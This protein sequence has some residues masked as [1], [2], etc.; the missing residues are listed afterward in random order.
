VGGATSAQRMRGRLRWNVTV[1]TLRC[2]LRSR[3]SSVNRIAAGSVTDAVDAL[4]G[5][6]PNLHEAFNRRHA[7]RGRARRRV[8]P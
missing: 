8:M 5:R 7:T 6:K 1:A 2:T 4:A 3:Q